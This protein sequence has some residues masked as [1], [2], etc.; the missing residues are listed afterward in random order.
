MKI[1]RETRGAHQLGTAYEE[2]TRGE[3]SANQGKRP[4]GN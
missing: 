4:W 2:V 3:M 1:W